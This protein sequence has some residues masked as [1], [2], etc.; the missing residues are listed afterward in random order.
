V[1]NSYVEVEGVRENAGPDNDGTG[2]R[3]DT[4]R[5]GKVSA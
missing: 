4:A 5:L 1:T 2:G 3:I